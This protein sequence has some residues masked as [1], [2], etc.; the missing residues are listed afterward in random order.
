MLVALHVT[1]AKFV[2]S[3]MSQNWTPNVLSSTTNLKS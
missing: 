1:F 3:E 2:V